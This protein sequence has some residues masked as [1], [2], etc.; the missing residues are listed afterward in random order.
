MT[1]SG[2]LGHEWQDLK[3]MLDLLDFFNK[4]KKGQVLWILNNY[5][6]NHY[7]QQLKWAFVLYMSCISLALST[8]FREQTT[9]KTAKKKIDSY[10]SKNV[11]T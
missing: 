10:W 3:Q 4:L 1:H 6:I 8:M 2:P 7:H 5:D 9:P 11:V